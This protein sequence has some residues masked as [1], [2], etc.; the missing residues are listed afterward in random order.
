MTRIL[1]LILCLGLVAACDSG[2]GSVLQE[3]GETDPDTDNG[4]SGGDDGEPIDSTRELPPGTENPTPTS[5]IFR[6]EPF[7]QE[8]GNGYVR[9]ARYDSENDQFF[10]EGLGF[11]GDQ[12]DGQAF[13]RSIPG[14]LGNSYALYEAPALFPDSVTGTPIP[15]FEHRAVYGVSESG[16]TEFA[17]VRTG[18]YVNYGFGGFLYQR[19]GEVVLPLEGQGTYQGDYAA[20][21]DFDGRGGLEYAEG[22]ARVDVDFSGFR[23]NCSAAECDN[24]VRGRV[25][26]RRLFDTAG[27][28][29]TRAY[30]DVLSAANEG[31]PLSQM[32]ILSFKIGPNVADVNGEISGDVFSVSTEATLQSNLA[33]SG[34]YY[35][36]MA[37]D[38][39]A[40]PGGE[41]V[42]VVVIENEDPRFENVTVR[43]TGGFIAVRR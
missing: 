42:G 32:P 36:V 15:Q 35:I 37:G 28:D 11:D 6:R 26:D 31:V 25:F 43:E 12:P 33:D 16:E 3:P 21:R 22:T 9:A 23:A 27:N 5:A 2:G 19:N 20:I 30:L 40:A 13:S 39:T 10:V 14:T 24:A 4:S 18:A 8:V 38:H 7:D 1:L 41:M 29:I 17:I 34:K